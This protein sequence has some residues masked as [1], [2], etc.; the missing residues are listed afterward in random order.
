MAKATNILTKMKLAKNSVPTALEALVQE[1]PRPAHPLH[2]RR[3]ESLVLPENLACFQR[4]AAAELNQP[5]RGRALHHRFVLIVA[6]QTAATVCV[7]DREFRLTPGHG[8]LIFP[9][10]FHHYL[11]AEREKLCWLFVTFEY[12]DMDALQTLRF[13]PFALDG[14]LRGLLAKLLEAYRSKLTADLAVLL[15]GVLLARLRLAKKADS[16][17]DHAAPSLVSQVNLYAHRATERVGVKELAGALGISPT[18]LRARFRASTGVSLGRHLRR[19][20]LERAC[21]LLRMSAARVTEIA[22][23]CGFNSIYSFSRAFRV[24]YGFSPLE[25]RRSGAKRSAAAG[26]GAA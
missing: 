9:F 14:E 20:R 6:L 8:L 17:P 7:D 21:G 18:H 24:A 26:P 1:L 10:Q 4:R 12:A 2:G 15:T 25:Y 11:Q 5:R 13:R 16:G 23:Q 22:E 19:L 3:P